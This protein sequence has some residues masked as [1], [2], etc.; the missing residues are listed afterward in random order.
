VWEKAMKLRTMLM[1]AA[2]LAGSPLLAQTTSTGSTPARQPAHQPGVPATSGATSKAGAAPPTTTDKVD[3][4]KEAAIRHLMDLTQTSKMGDDF[5]RY[6]TNQV[7]E[8]LSQALPPDRLSKLME[9]FSAKLT[10]AMPAN[11]ITDAAVPIYA[12]AFSM[13]DLQ[14]LIQ[15]YESPLGQR[16]VKTLPRVAQESERVGVQMEQRSAMKILQDMSTDYPE[17]KSMLQPPQEN[18]GTEMP[19]GQKAPAPA[20]PA[21]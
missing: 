5:N 19:G 13:E 3:P 16:V 1:A 4:A 9:T 20:P 6:V 8:V 12:E 14:G 15:F 10:V 21:K 2:F 7:H 17:L 11:A 18:G